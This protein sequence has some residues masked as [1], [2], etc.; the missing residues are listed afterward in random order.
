[1]KGKEFEFDILVAQKVLNLKVGWKRFS[2]NSYYGIAT[3]DPWFGGGPE[4]SET[5]FEG[6]CEDSNKQRTWE[7]DGKTYESS[8]PEDYQSYGWLENGARV[9]PYSTDIS[10]AWDIVDLLKSG[11]VSGYGNRPIVLD[12]SYN[13]IEKWRAEFI[14]TN[15]HAGDDRSMWL[16]KADTAPLAICL[17]A[18]DFN[19]IETGYPPVGEK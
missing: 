15:D 18:L 5:K 2:G 19:E 10:W 12:L 6:I 3:H 16:G 4:W 14:L 13:T 7:R 11:Q 8:I 1:M 17:A 9:H